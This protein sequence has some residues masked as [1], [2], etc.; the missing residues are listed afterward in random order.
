[1]THQGA[2][3]GDAVAATTDIEIV[4]AAVLVV[5]KGI[6]EA[7][8]AE[9]G[10]SLAALGGVVVDDIQQ[11]L[12]VG[13]VAGRHQLTHLL[14]ALQG[15]ITDQVA[16]MGGHPAQGAVAPVIEASGGGILGIEGHHRQQLDRRHPQLLQGG[17]HLDQAQQG[18]LALRADLAAR[19]LGEAADMQ[20]VD[21]ALLPAMAG[22]GGAGEVEVIPFGHHPLEAA[23]GVGH[24]PDRR[25][26]LVHRPAG[27][28][29]GA[30]IEQ[31][32][33]GIEAVAAALQRAEGPIAIAT[34][35]AD[36]LHL[37]MPVV[38]GA[39]LQIEFDHLLRFAGLGMGEQQQVQPRGQRGNDGEVDAVGGA[40]CPQWPGMS[41]PGRRHWARGRIDSG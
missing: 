26:P 3:G 34:A 19:A 32:L 17:Q 28:R 23:G 30:G 7:T 22:P 39:V 40:R 10:A 8:P 2:I 27:D 12:H 4:A 24:G 25:S 41:D 14:A 36:A 9:G 5:V 37:H 18:A 35:D 20:F 16:R 33:G 38:A 1:M 21:D 13:A 31:H 11:H 6:A 15:V 29:P